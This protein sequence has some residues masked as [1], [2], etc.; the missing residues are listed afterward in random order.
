MVS[1]EEVI[2][3][4]SYDFMPCDGRYD[5]GDYGET[6][7]K[8]PR[9]QTVSGDGWSLLEFEPGQFLVVAVDARPGTLPSQPGDRMNSA[10]KW[11][12]IEDFMAERAARRS[13]SQASVEEAPARAQV[14]AF[15]GATV[16]PPNTLMAL[17]DALSEEGQA[18][19]L[20]YARGR[21]RRDRR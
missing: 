8:Y 9:L 1:G 10:R 11:G 20:A 16:A 18:D 2:G 14:I 7:I 3:C 21:L 12:S 4:G 15:P 13:R 17:N 6:A 5:K 19:L